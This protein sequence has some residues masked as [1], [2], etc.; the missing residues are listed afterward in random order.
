[1]KEL[2]KL[3]GTLLG[4]AIFDRIPIKCFLNR[5]ILR[6]LASQPVHFSD[7]FDYDEKMYDSFKSILRGTS[8]EELGLDFCIYK[9]NRD[10]SL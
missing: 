9:T 3:L 7:F 6:Q 2:S 8:A 4:K 5:T 10:D 1:M